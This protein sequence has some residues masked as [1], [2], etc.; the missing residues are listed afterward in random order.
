MEIIKVIKYDRLIGGISYENSILPQG[1]D[2]LKFNGKT[3]IDFESSVT[4][5]SYTIEVDS[6]IGAED[7]EVDVML[8]DNKLYT[9][10]QSDV[11][12]FSDF[13]IDYETEESLK[14]IKRSSGEVEIKGIRIYLGEK[15]HT[16]VNIPPLKLHEQRKVNL[17]G[18][19]V[20]VEVEMKYVDHIKQDYV[21]LVNT[22]SKGEQPFRINNIEKGKRRIKFEA[23]HIMW[24]LD[25]MVV[26]GFH[27]ENMGAANVMR[28]IMKRAGEDHPFEV[29]VTREAV[30]THTFPT[31]SALQCIKDVLDIWIG[32]LD[33]NKFTIKLAEDLGEDR[34]ET[35]S[36][37]KNLEDIRVWE[38]WDGVVTKLL[39][40]G[41]DGYTLPEKFI[42]AP[43]KYNKTYAGT[44]EFQWSDGIDPQDVLEEVLEDDLRQQAIKFLEKAQY[45]KLAYQV[46]S[47]IN[48]EMDLWDHIL[49]KHPSISGVLP[50]DGPL[51]QAMEDNLGV[52]IRV[53]SY[54]YDVLAGRVTTIEYGSFSN[55]MRSIMNEREDKIKE[56][57]ENIFIDQEGR[58]DE[59]TEL[60]NNWNKKGHVVIE[61]DVIYIVDKLPK[62]DAKHVLRIGLAGI[63]FSDTGIDG[64][65]TSGWDLEGNFNADW[66]TAGTLEGSLLR[67][68]SIEAEHL[69][70]SAKSFIMSLMKSGGANLLKNSVGYAGLQ[71]PWVVEGAVPPRLQ[72]IYDINN[73]EVD[74]DSKGI[75]YKQELSAMEKSDEKITVDDLAFNVKVEE[76]RETL[77]ELPGAPSGYKMFQWKSSIGTP[78]IVTLK[79]T[80]EK[81]KET[82]GLINFDIEMATD[83]K[84][85]LQKE[86]P[87]EMEEVILE[88]TEDLT[89]IGSANLGRARGF[90]AYQGYG[91]Q[92]LF[93][94]EI[95]PSHY[96]TRE[97]TFLIK[98]DKIEKMVPS[99]KIELG[100]VETKDGIKMD[101]DLWMNK[102]FTR[103]PAFQLEGK[104]PTTSGTPLP[105]GTKALWVRNIVAYH[106]KLDPH[107]IESYGASPFK[108]SKASIEW[109]RNSW[110]TKHVAKHGWIFTDPNAA[111]SQEVTVPENELLTLSCNVLKSTPA[112]SVTISARYGTSK[113]GEST[114]I[115]KT[116]GYQEVHDGPI[117]LTIP[118]R[119]GNETITVTLSVTNTSTANPVQIDDV[120]LGRGPSTHW[121]QADG[122]LYTADVQF[123]ADGIKVIR[124]DP[125]SG[126]EIGYTSVTP[127]DFSGWYDGERVFT[128]N[129]DITEVKGLNVGGLGL[130]IKPVKMVQNLKGN[131]SL[132]IVWTGKDD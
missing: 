22:K 87:G 28:E 61:N 29:V 85:K 53:L 128:L 100:V 2:N 66:I 91:N 35:I 80:T 69:S 99:D 38:N 25:R 115:S 68:E 107:S 51:N 102:P 78:P 48:Q 17:D 123:D 81:A 6:V 118:A 86:T 132:D 44:H 88:A 70:L 12:Q 94:I 103:F 98:V 40:T 11:M 19:Y 113:E 104:F 26:E 1:M 52:P 65:F 122:E 116:I 125:E 105:D 82:I 32:K 121:Q 90:S 31:Q 72:G 89:D 77:T 3:E 5:G 93:N 124:R 112:G 30:R 126:Q 45:P 4:P 101:Y 21:I 10:F 46:S 110:N 7:S 47:N 64:T 117:A 58:L 33:V 14:L 109:G 36:Y 39:P 76:E 120:F 16:V 37:G 79:V 23:N 74:P 41:P 83:K 60:I 59:Q 49:V 111:I 9:I 84:V 57:I 24:D 92:V 27:V 8:G 71:L 75:V 96:A 13:T 130:Y 131:G 18:W 62:E 114:V 63:A 127:F 15:I 56:E 54:T 129:D 50:T 67:V 20:E 97:L 108:G 95:D 73:W 42:E 55:S 119:P 34:G 106:T 43:I